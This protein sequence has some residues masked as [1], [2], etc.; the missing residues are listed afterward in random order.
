MT[1]EAG[2]PQEGG[3]MGDFEIDAEARR[4]PMAGAAVN[5]R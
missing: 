3:E 2:I 5:D 4:K 1:N